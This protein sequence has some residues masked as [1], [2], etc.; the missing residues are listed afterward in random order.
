MT[1]F[2]IWLFIGWALFC[3]SVTF[4]VFTLGRALKL[5]KIKPQRFFVVFLSFSMLWPWVFP[6][7]IYENSG[8][9]RRWFRK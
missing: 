6:F 9:F 1:V 5:T 3:L 2:V 8:T 4:E 7:W